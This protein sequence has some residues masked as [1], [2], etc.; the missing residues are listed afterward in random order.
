MD[1]KST[2]ADK[3][4]RAQLRTSRDYSRFRTICTDLRLARLGLKS[5]GLN[6]W[7]WYWEYIDAYLF[8]PEAAFATKLKTRQIW[9]PGYEFDSS[10]KDLTKKVEREWKRLKLEVALKEGCKNAFIWGNEYLASQDNS[11]AKFA[12]GTPADYAQ[13]AS[14]S[15][16]T[17]APR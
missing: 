5:S 6:D 9:K 17:G 16:I 11:D 1:R 8:V 12:E 3:Y 7:G 15:N 13:G 10:N 2:R 14:F 4:L